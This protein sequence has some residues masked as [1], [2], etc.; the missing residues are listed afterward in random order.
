MA[1]TTSISLLRLAVIEPGQRLVKDNE[2][3]LNRQRARHFEA[4]EMTQREGRCRLVLL[5]REPDL[6]ENRARAR[7]LRHALAPQQRSEWVRGKPVTRGKCHIFQDGH[8]AERTDD[9]VRRCTC[10][11]GR[12]SAVGRSVTSIAGNKDAARIRCERAGNDANEMVFPAPFGPI[13]PTS[14]P[15]EIE[16]L[17]SST[18][19]TP[20]K[21]IAT[22]ATVK[23]GR[24]LCTRHSYNRTPM[25]AKSAGAKRI[26]RTSK[27]AEDQQPI[28]IDEAKHLGQQ[29]Q[30]NGCANPTPQ[31]DPVPPITT[32]AIS[33]TET[34]KP[35]EVRDDE[36]GEIGVKAAGKTRDRRSQREGNEL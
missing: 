10:P 22:A 7:F 25:P 4:L 11:C 19:I 20:P 14:S 21:R 26:I 28:V 12:A 9:L 35:K 18:A 23:R 13:R 30:Q 32:I 3:R 1:T 15:D 36:L 6:R 8:G 16:R 33:I 5:A 17:T 34:M 29:G 31:V 2:R 27:P 24:H